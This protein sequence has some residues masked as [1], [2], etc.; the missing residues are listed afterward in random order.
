M[1]LEEL[2]YERIA[3]EEGSPVIHYYEKKFKTFKRIIYFYD[4]GKEKGWACQISMIVGE[5][6][7][8]DKFYDEFD[9]DITLAI[10]EELKDLGWIE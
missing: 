9:L 7:T 4:D 5:H 6:H 2:G 3:D 10:M 1:T 8:D